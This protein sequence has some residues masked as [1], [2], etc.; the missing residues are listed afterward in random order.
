MTT[1]EVKELV[2]PEFV[3]ELFVGSV[4]DSSQPRWAITIGGKIVTIGGKIFFDTREQAVEGFYN[5]F[6]W[7]ARRKLYQALHPEDT[8][9][10][11]WRNAESTVMWKGFKEAITEK[12]GFKIIQ[13]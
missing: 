8:G 4:V 10:G 5:S 6:S 9:W 12:F 2:S 3:R 7:R 1:A 13:V 11:W